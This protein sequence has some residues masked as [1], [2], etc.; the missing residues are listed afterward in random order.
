[1]LLNGAKISFI[2]VG[3]RTTAVVASVQKK[4][5]MTTAPEQISDEPEKAVEE[6]PDVEE[7]TLEAKKG[8]VKNSAPGMKSKATKE[9]QEITTSAQTS[10]GKSRAVKQEDNPTTP[11]VTDTEDKHQNAKE[12]SEPSTTT[13]VKKP[14]R[15]NRGVGDQVEPPT[16]E[17]TDTKAE[18]NRAQT[19]A[20]S[21]KRKV[22]T[23]VPPPSPGPTHTTTDTADPPSKKQKLTPSRSSIHD[24]AVS[25]EPV[26][27]PQARK[28]ATA[29]ATA[30]QSQPTSKGVATS[31]EGEGGETR[32]RSRRVSGRA[33]G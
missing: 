23:E 24:P 17:P 20:T 13:P 18:T 7:D 4:T 33:P 15:K 29:A 32:R 28:K 25:A 6:D 5:E 27:L 3:G 19:S 30:G 31:A 26:T 21:K 11:D 10:K 12:L 22:T 1:M 2:T 14:H 16:P 8:R 9:P